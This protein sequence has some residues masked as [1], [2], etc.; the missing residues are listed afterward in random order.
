MKRAFLLIGVAVA[1]LL[2]SVQTADAG[3]NVRIG[4]GHY[5]PGY[6]GHRHF[7]FHRHF[8]YG[9]VGFHR[10]YF[11]GYYRPFRSFYPRTFV[12][13][14]R[15]FYGSYY[16]PPVYGGYGCH[17][18]GFGAYAPGVIAPLY[19]DAG[20]VYGPDAVKEFLGVDRD[21]AKGP[22]APRPLVIDVKPADDGRRIVAAPDKDGAPDKHAAAPEE[23]I[24]SNREARQRAARF[25]SFGD[26]RFGEQQYHSA[27][28]RYRFAIE[29]APDVA[30]AHFRQGFAYVASN[31]YELALESFRR[32]L[33]LDP[34]WVN[35][36]F[37]LEDLYGRNAL[38]KNSH[39]DGLA[40]SALID[41]GNPDHFFLLGVML[42][43]D[44]Q[45]ERAKKFFDRADK[46]AG[47]DNDHIA[48]FLEAPKPRPE[49][50]I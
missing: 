36:S 32:G 41:R 4:L 31:R 3:I 11:R 19:A 48:A 12:Y 29:A 28:Q 37:R 2:F 14:S 24:A 43:F 40:K 7:G 50:A 16:Y 42:H 18:G 38:A 34:L 27:A 30:E 6:F 10:N 1:A 13:Y 17:Y 49:D 5:H 44:G 8:G 23:R 22:L 46:L 25:V 20:S 9:H 39:L 21:F 33:Q 45:Q 35:S 47:G 26:D 15:P